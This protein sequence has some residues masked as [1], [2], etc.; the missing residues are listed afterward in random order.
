MPPCNA[1]NVD[2]VDGTFVPSTDLG[3]GISKDTRDEMVPTFSEDVDTIANVE[4]V[5]IWKEQRREVELTQIVKGCVVPPRETC[6]LF[7]AFPYRPPV[8]FMLMT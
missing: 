5:L 1:I 4:L 8:I 2:P 6:A 3:W 7:A